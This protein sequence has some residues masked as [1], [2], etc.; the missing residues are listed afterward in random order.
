LHR[1]E[2]SLLRCEDDH[3][4]AEKCDYRRTQFTKPQWKL[5]EDPCPIFESSCAYRR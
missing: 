3:W 1:L 2:S 5:D 4:L